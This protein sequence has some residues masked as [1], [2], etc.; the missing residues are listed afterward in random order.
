MTNY[1]PIVDIPQLFSNI[2]SINSQ[3]LAHTFNIITRSLWREHASQRHA[4]P[5]DNST[6][7][8]DSNGLK[9]SVAAVTAVTAVTSKGEAG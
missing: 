2:V 6:M 7:Y 9:H 4:R 1:K 5:V 3:V 8:V